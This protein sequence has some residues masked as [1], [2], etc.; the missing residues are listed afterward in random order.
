MLMNDYKT[1][2]KVC[3]LFMRLRYIKH[4]GQNQN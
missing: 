1:D 4:E 3:E 2:D